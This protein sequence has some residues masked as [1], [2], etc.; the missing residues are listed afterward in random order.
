MKKCQKYIFQ[1]VFI[2]LFPKLY[3]VTSLVIYS[4]YTIFF[5]L[6]R[7]PVENICERLSGLGS[8]DVEAAL[9]REWGAGQPLTV[10]PTEENYPGITIFQ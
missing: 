3:V 9:V 7:S 4:I 10:H 8:E 5:C 1:D 6:F 2:E